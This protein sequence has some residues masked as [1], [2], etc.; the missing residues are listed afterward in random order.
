MGKLKD[1]KEKE[2]N[3]SKATQE[4]PRPQKEGDEVKE[5]NITVEPIIGAVGGWSETDREPPNAQKEEE[6]D[7]KRSKKGKQRKTKRKEH[8]MS[9]SEESEKTNSKK[10]NEHKQDDKLKEVEDRYEKEMKEQSKKKV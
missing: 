3:T 1:V 5:D 4:K 6:I 7:Q 8:E 9:T 2:K 10:D